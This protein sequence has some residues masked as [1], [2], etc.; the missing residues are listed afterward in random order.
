MVIGEYLTFCIGEFQSDLRDMDLPDYS[1]S[2]FGIQRTGPSSCAG[3]EGLGRRMGRIPSLGL[4]GGS[5]SPFF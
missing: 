2:A 4:V 3:S 1:I 5:E